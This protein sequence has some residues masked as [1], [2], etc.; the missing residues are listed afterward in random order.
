[1]D[2]DRSLKIIRFVC[3]V[4]LSLVAQ[5]GSQDVVLVNL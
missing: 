2:Y 4:C 3:F 5:P 1:V